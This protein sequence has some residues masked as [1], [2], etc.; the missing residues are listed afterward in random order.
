VVDSDA[1]VRGSIL[2]DQVFIGSH[3]VVDRCI[4]DKGVN[5]GAF[6][7]LGYGERRTPGNDITVLGEGVTIPR[8][9]AIGRSCKIM[10]YTGYGDFTMHAI[11]PGQ[12]VSPLAGSRETISDDRVIIH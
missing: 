1:L 8:R 9:T 4:L 12:V 10:P 7:Y 6:C 2:M 11:T 5:V 3:S